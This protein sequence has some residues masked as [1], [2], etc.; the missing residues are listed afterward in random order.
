MKNYKKKSYLK[1]RLFYLNMMKIDLTWHK[2]AQSFPSLKEGLHHNSFEVLKVRTLSWKR[3]P[4]K[5]VNV[6]VLEKK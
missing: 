2:W 6:W 4:V 3:I 5:E 1:Q